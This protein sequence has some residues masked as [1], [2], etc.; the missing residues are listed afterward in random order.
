MRLSGI[1]H[2]AATMAVATAAVVLA[3]AGVTY[4]LTYGPQE[5]P[6]VSDLPVVVTARAADLEP[7][8]PD[9][10]PSASVGVMPGANADA[11]MAAGGA[12]KPTSTENRPSS[13]TAHVTAPKTSRGSHTDKHEVVSPPVHESGGKEHHGKPHQED[14][15]GD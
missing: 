8:V 15:Q 12:S 7:A 2:S 10:V 6:G 1:A 5:T 14:S 4:A 11:H 13:T 3:A 9:A